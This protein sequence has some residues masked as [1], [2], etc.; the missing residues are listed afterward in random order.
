MKGLLIIISA[1]SGCGKTSLCRRLVK[2]CPGLVRS[3]SMT[4]RKP[5]KGEKR[6]TD[7]KFVSEEKFKQLKKSGKFLEWAKVFGHYYGTPVDSVDKWT[8]KG[9]DVLLTIDVQGALKVHRKRPQAISVFILPPSSSELKKR[10]CKRK[11]ES[12]KEAMKRFKIANWEMAHLRHY[13]YAVIN[14]NL[15]SAVKSVGSIIAAERCST[16][17]I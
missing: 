2:V 9:R 12:P 8:K 5:R 7:Y 3:V 10:L 1:P 17:R 14:D 15:S 6:G 16:G 4:T 11:T 13:D